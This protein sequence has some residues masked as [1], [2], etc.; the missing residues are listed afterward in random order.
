MMIEP[1]AW[2]ARNAATS[3]GEGTRSNSSQAVSVT[4][5][6]RASRSRPCSTTSWSPVSVRMTPGDSLTS[7]KSKRGSPSAVRS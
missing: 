7:A 2:A 1:R 6:E 5:S 4:M 3:S